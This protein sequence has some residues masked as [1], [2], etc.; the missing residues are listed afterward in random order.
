LD[1]E[2]RAMKYTKENRGS[3]MSGEEA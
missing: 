2:E 1:D 3:Y